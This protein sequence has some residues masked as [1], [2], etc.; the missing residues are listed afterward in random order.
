MVKKLFLNK[1]WAVATLFSIS[2]ALYGIDFSIS[3]NLRDISARLPRK[4]A[5]IS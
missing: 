2:L 4:L 1:A 5:D 3:G